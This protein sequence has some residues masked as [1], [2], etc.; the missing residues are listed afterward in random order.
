MQSNKKM[1]NFWCCLREKS[2]PPPPVYLD[3]KL[4]A[5]ALFSFGIFDSFLACSGRNWVFGLYCSIQ[6]VFQSVQTSSARQTTDAK[7]LLSK[8]TYCAAPDEATSEVDSSF[9]GTFTSRRFGT[10]Q[11]SSWLEQWFCWKS[12]PYK[13]F[14]FQVLHIC[15]GKFF[16]LIVWTLLPW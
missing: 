1:S 13:E 14:Y 11:G 16:F 15:T 9:L 4:L 7:S 6:M 5:T 3:S 8:S 10:L 12:A 2:L